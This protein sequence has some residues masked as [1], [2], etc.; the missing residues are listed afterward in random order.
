MHAINSF[1]FQTA[2]TIICLSLPNGYK[3][4]VYPP[5]PKGQKMFKKSIEPPY[6]FDQN[7]W[8][9]FGVLYPPWKNPGH[10][11]GLSSLFFQYLVWEENRQ[12]KLLHDINP[13][14]I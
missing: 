14:F 11:T 7:V 5:P 13:I 3:G 10:R 12:S 4:Y 8:N 2:Y 1:F 6:V 9:F